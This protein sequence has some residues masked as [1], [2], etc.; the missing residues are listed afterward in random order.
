MLSIISL[1]WAYSS[2]LDSEAEFKEIVIEAG[3][4]KKE[5][6]QLLEDEGIIRNRHVFSF[7]AFFSDSANNLKAGEYNLSASMSVRDIINALFVGEIKEEVRVTIPEGLSISE[8]EEILIENELVEKGEFVRAASIS[9]A[10]AY[11][12]YEYEFLQNLDGK[13]LEGF[14]FPDTYN[15]FVEDI[16][17]EDIVDK[18]LGNF[19]IR[20]KDIREQVDSYD[21]MRVIITSSLVQGE[22]QTPEDMKLLAGQIQNRLDAGV[23]LQLD[24]TLLYITGRHDRS[25]IPDLDKSIDSPY[26]TYLVRGITPTPINN[27]G[28]VAIDAVLNPTPSDYFYHVSTPDGTTYFSKTLEEHNAN[29][30]K[31]LIQPR[32]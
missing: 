30:Y 32:Q 6:A 8:I 28:L 11:E 14:L 2:P 25:I 29:V 13:N 12:E 20:T 21:L 17:P 10:N 4:G 23:A 18:L 9:T 3:M 22:V 24:V 15:F 1:L 5:I 16:T 19:E 27:P 26:N 7:F 31:Y